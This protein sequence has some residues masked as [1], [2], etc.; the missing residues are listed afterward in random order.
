MIRRPILK[1]ILLLAVVGVVGCT[2]LSKVGK[3]I[4]D[5]SVP[6][7][8]PKDEPTQLAFSINASPT[9]NGN[10]NS[11]EAQA[12]PRDTPEASAYSVSLS[13]AGPH[14]LTEKV[15]TLL[16]Y[17]Q[18]QFPA[19]SLTVPQDMED[20]PL[21]RSPLEE[22]APGH[23]DDSTVEVHLPTATPGVTEQIATP[24]A[25]KILQ[26][27]DDSLLRNTTFQM[28]NQAPAKALRSTYIR[29]DDYLLLP[30]Q[31][32]FLPFEPVHADTRF[33]AII[34]DYRNPEQT[35]W[36]QVLRI[37]PRG[38]Q[39]VLSVLLNDTRLVLKEED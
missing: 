3:V 23:Y 37:V 10:P 25:I 13:A 36:Q 35:T 21:P 11:V 4:M 6:V 29:D 15:G 24:M 12:E 9:L 22:G 32:K 18:A 38:R 16:A 28:L 34:A 31:F 33:I 1:L 26:L 20:N 7:G 17:L 39:M 19:I 5:P 30:G 14:A 2:A 8:A 27:R